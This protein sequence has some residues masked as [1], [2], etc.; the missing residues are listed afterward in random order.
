[1]AIFNNYLEI[2]LD[3]TGSEVSPLSVTDP[4]NLYILKGSATAIGNYAISTSGTPYKGLTYTFLYRGS[5]NITT[6]GTT[7]KIFGSS[8]FTQQQLYRTWKAECTYNGTTWDVIL[9]MDFLESYIVN[10]SNIGALDASI[11]QN[12]TLDLGAKGINLSL[13][14]AK[15]AD[16]AVTTAKIDNLAVTDANISA[17]DGSKINAAT[18][19]NAKLA[20]MA[21]QTV[22]ANV[23]G[24]VTTPSDVPISTILSGSTWGLQGNSGTSPGT[25]FVGTTD[26]QDLVFKTN[27]VESGRINI[28]SGNTSFGQ[29]AL[30]L[31]TSG[32]SNTAIGFQS[33]P[34]TTSG[35]GNTSVGR[36]AL[37]DNTTGLSNTAVGQSAGDTI[38][39]GGDNTLIGYGAD[40]N[41]TS[42]NNR[43]ALGSGAV[44][45][46]NF[47]F[48]LP[49]NVTEFK[50]RGNSFTLPSAYGN[51]D[52]ILVSDG[53]GGLSFDS[54]ID[55][56]TYTPT[57]TDVTNV[58]S[59]TP[60][61]CKYT[62]VG[63][64]VTVSGKVGINATGALATELQMTLP[65]ASNL[66]SNDLNGT[67]GSDT[68]NVNSVRI[69]ADPVSNE[70]AFI[71]DASASGN[72]IYGFVF[73]Y[74]II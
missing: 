73:M 49:D 19:T 69:K 32:D 11:I 61:A 55:S 25:D 4:Y 6:N 51:A 33:Q 27:S 53:S 30:T 2:T 43:I 57:L 24:G 21:D 3:G 40:V 22:K 9:Y 42:A 12:G 28:A 54:V 16:L 68:N 58:S 36:E 63:S 34:Q 15:I 10:S 20:T 64:M 38:I 65:I 45:D 1:M 74:E 35:K 37:S 67:A 39:T 13:D 59:S 50:F 14:T 48:A 5:L 31:V 60:Y 29:S 7:F 8:N 52:S 26:A 23:S 17:V 71:F 56:G 46:Q 70:A 47:Q 44:A 72:S 41:S 18:V 62:K 66:G